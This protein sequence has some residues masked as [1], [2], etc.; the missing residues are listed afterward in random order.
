[1]Q[2]S[3]I[4]K[5]SSVPVKSLAAQNI[6][7]KQDPMDA[8]NDPNAKIVS[9][10]QTINLLTREC[11]IVQNGG[12]ITL[13]LDP[14]SWTTNYAG[15]VLIPGMIG[16]IVDIN[17]IVSLLRAHHIAMNDTHAQIMANPQNQ[18]PTVNTIITAGDYLWVQQGSNFELELW[19]ADG[20]THILPIPI[21]AMPGLDEGI[22][23]VNVF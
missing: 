15:I 16:R 4:L 6:H 22:N 3:I 20:K 11:L 2:R 14:S 17:G 5:S 13:T 7:L 9:P 18:A 23:D 19:A 8:W 10:N 1:M 12:I 21:I